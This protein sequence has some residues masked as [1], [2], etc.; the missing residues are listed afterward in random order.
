MPRRNFIP[1]EP[2]ITLTARAS[3]GKIVLAELRADT[4]AQ[5]KA[6]DE[7]GEIDLAAWQ[8]IAVRHMVETEFTHL[9]RAEKDEWLAM[10][11]VGLAMLLTPVTDPSH[12]AKLL[13][14][15]LA[16]LRVQRVRGSA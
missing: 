12:D 2:G 13:A 8:A 3:T 16:L 10:T 15:E 6:D 4:S 1:A 5:F 7:R 9:T 11:D 14:Y